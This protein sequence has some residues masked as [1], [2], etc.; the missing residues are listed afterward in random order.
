LPFTILLISVA[1]ILF[2]APIAG[3]WCFYLIDSEQTWIRVVL[4]MTMGFSASVLLSQLLTM[5]FYRR[6]P[7]STIAAG[8]FS[9]FFGAIGIISSGITVLVLLH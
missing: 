6:D 1:A 7:G 9:L 3:T 5:I 2:V 4:S 8:C